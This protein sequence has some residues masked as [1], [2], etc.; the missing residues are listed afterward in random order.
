MTGPKRDDRTEET[1]RIPP[2]VATSI[3]APWAAVARPDRAQRPADVDAGD[4]IGGDQTRGAA[5]YAGGQPVPAP[6]PPAAA[7]GGPVWQAAPTAPPVGQAEPAAA[8][9]RAVTTS[10]VEAATGAATPVAAATGAAAGPA[11][12]LAAGDAGPPAP[13]GT[14]YDS[15]RPPDDGHGATRSAGRL[16]ALR[17]GWHT[18]TLPSL[19]RLG[20]SSLGSGLILG[21]DLRRQPVP[22]RV[23]RPEPTRITLVGGVWAGVYVVFRALAVGARV[24]VVTAEPQAWHGFGERATGHADR[25]WVIGQEQP[26]PPSGSAQQPMLAIYDLGLVGPTASPPLG[27]WQTQLTVLRRL[28]QSGVPSLQEA[29]LVVLQRLGE[30]E[31]SRASAALRLPERSVGLL[32]VM[33]DDM[34][35]LIG[36]GAGR[37]VWLTQTEIERHH[38]GPPRR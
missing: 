33:A 6:R 35:A 31:A 26:L 16:T 13:S 36:G 18:A 14:G 7:I 9:G 23:F 8:L 4:P 12:A 5:R 15:Q 2:A 21:A 19:A 10:A 34:A 32:Q 28:D 29:D 25:V 11:E 20:P 38:T 17:I 3:G 37:Y 27:P 1:Q 30:A 24:V 22:V